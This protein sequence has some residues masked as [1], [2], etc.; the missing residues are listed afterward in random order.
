MCSGNRLLRKSV[1]IPRPASGG[2]SKT[3]RGQPRLHHTSAKPKESYRGTGSENSSRFPEIVWNVRITLTNDR[4]TLPNNKNI[5]PLARKCANLHAPL[6]GSNST[7]PHHQARTRPWNGR[8]KQ[9]R[10]HTEPCSHVSACSHDPEK[11]QISQ[12]QCTWTTRMR[13][14]SRDRALA[15]FLVR[16]KSFEEKE[17]EVT[18]KEVRTKRAK[19]RSRRSQDEESSG[20]VTT[21]SRIEKSPAPLTVWGWARSTRSR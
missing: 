9:G 11:S 19:A 16:T 20:P 4:H 21:K 5:S 6:E 17:E 15:L 8:S 1:A 13:R 7:R 14:K 10:S 18:S 2:K 3:N 12:R